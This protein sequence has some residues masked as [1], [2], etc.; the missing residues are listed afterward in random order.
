MS[1]LAPPLKLFAASDA[2]AADAAASVRLVLARGL[3]AAATVGWLLHD[4]RHVPWQRARGSTLA[5]E[6]VAAA[7]EQRQT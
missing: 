5:G 2:G 6:V 7:A 4:H 1:P 3:L